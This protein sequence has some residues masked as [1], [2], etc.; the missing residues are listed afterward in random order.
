[1]RVRL[2]RS[3]GFKE[4]LRRSEGSAADAALF[5]AL[6]E[7]LGLKLEPRK[8]P[9]EMFVIEYAERPERLERLEQ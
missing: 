2:S 3:R 4:P 9:V 7:Q 6:Q 8:G 1:M 5:A